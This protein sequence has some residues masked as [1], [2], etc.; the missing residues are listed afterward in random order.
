MH[1]CA[2]VFATL[3]SEQKRP[4]RHSVKETLT[5]HGTDF[6]DLVK[7]E[8]EGEEEWVLWILFIVSF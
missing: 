7:G 8:R 5:E 2:R 3:I 4:Q 1:G 6:K